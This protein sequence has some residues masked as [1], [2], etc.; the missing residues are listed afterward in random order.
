M[1]FW[2][3]VG[4][5][6]SSGKARE[7]S[8][9]IL[10]AEA[11]LL[12]EAGIVED[13][14]SRRTGGWIIPF[15]VVVEKT[16]GLRRRWIAWPRDKKIDDP[17]EADVPLFY[18]SHYLPPVMAE[19]ASCLD[20]KASFLKSLYRG[21]LGISF[22]AA[23]RRHAGGAH[24]A[25]NGMQS[26]PRNS[27]DYYFSNCGADDGGSPPLGRTSTGACRRMDR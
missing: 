9:R 17:Y 20:L 23:W 6:L 26:Q 2:G 13:A 11:R 24:T 18:S 14:L 16:T 27:P 7:G 5:F 10:V 3:L 15:S 21:R 1:P 4:R 19:A 12:R 25:P 22:D 8:R